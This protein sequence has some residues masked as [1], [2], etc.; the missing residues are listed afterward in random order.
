MLIPKNWASFQH[1]KDRNPPWIKLHKGLLNDRAYT[2]LPIASKALAPLL[3]LLASESKEGSFEA[4]VE[5]LAFRLRMTEKEI[6]Q[7][8]DPLIKSGFF[9][10]VQSDSN[11]LAEGL[12]VAPK[13]CSETETER[14]A[15][16]KSA[17]FDL[18]WQ[19]YPNHAAK[20]NAV[21]AWMKIPAELHPTIMAAVLVQRV[22]TAWTK[23]NGQFV[24]HAATWLNGKRWEDSAPAAKQE[25]FV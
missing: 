22:S 24:P 20:Q 23:D 7:G 21:K 17:A 14:E 19:E 18:F 12:Q 8:L 9:M 6:T 11:V 25:S 5:E 13:S 16:T 1:Y 2:R 3:W 15:E 10:P 4:E